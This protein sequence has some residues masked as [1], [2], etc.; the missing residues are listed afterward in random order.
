MRIYIAYKF[1]GADKSQL[2]TEQKQIASAVEKSGN[3]PFI[4]YRDV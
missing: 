3:I 2:K 1:T 4:F